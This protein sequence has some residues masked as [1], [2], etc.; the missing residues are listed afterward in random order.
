M[1]AIPSPLNQHVLIDGMISSGKDRPIIA[2]AREPGVRPRRC[3]ADEA[4]RLKTG[5]AGKLM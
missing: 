5:Y 1:S 4:V 3:V 2:L